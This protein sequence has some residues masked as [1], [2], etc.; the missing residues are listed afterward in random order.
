MATFTKEF[1]ILTNGTLTAD[2]ASEVVVGAKDATKVSLYGHA[3][4]GG[5]TPSL[6][7]YV[8]TKDVNGNWHD[9]DNATAITA[10]GAFKKVG[11]TG[12]FGS[13][14]RL[15]YDVDVADAN[16][17]YTLVDAS[18]VVEFEVA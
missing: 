16:E 14:F 9:V 15:R 12:P 5:T 3:T 8:Q 6:T 17:T 13:F 4:L 2:G 18:L 1:A 10:T 11:I 7:V